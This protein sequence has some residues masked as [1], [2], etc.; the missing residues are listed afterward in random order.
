MRLRRNKA[1]MF[2]INQNLNVFDA[3]RHELDSMFASDMNSQNNGSAQKQH[4]KR[5]SRSQ[6][7]KQ[8]EV[9]PKSKSNFIEFENYC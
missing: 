9:E 5:H 8:K 1:A 4:S 2:K 3:D 7:K 6:F